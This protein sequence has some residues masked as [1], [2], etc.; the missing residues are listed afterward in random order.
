MHEPWLKHSQDCCLKAPQNHSLYNL[1]VSQLW[2][3]NMKRWDENKI[4]SL[5]PLEV[6]HDILTVPLLE[7]VKED[8]LIWTAE[9]NGVYSVRSGYRKLMKEEGRA[10]GSDMVEGWSSIWKI[11]A[12]P[13]A[14]HLLWRMCKECLPTRVRL[15][16]RY[17]QCPEEC[18]LCINYGEEEQHLFL[19][20]DSITEAWHVMGVANVIQSRVHLFANFR[21]LIF[22][23]CRYESKL[24]AGKVAILLWFA[25]KNRNNKVWNDSSIQAQQLGTQAANYWQQWAAVHG[26]LS[27]QLQPAQPA[28][29]AV[30]SMQWQQPPVDI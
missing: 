18:P 11:H 9:N 14:K 5:F 3:P 8:R 13:K 22:H 17:V 4:V 27:D 26:L 24:V 30:S 28:T 25:W 23:I 12:P 20:C 7:V 2:L 16:S 15:R 21:E 6:A 1:T 10:Y 29:A 19:Q